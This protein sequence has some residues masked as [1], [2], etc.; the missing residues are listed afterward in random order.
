MLAV[1]L[2]RPDTSFRKRRSK[3]RP[4]RWAAFSAAPADLT[5]N[6]GPPAGTG[7]RLN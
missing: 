2:S 3:R 6:R 7:R 1:I 4:R 5:T